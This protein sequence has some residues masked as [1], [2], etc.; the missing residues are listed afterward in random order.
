MSGG[1]FI[2]D[3]NIITALIKGERTI[4]DNIEKAS[5]IYIPITVLGELFMEPIILNKFLRILG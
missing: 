3:T 5:T 4:A 2:L 1:K